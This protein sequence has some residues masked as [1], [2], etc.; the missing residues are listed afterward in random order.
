[1]TFH[2]IIGTSRPGPVASSTDTVVPY[3]SSHLDVIPNPA[4][5]PPFGTVV[6]SECRVRSDHG[7][8]RDREAI[9]EVRRILLEHL[10]VA[11]SRESIRR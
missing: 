8:Q 6:A 10:A 7:V 5:R 1:V 4:E 9:R 2:S 11:Q 3:S